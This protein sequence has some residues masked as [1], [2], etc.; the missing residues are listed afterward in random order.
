MQSQS[1]STNFGPFE[2]LTLFVVNTGL[3]GV[4]LLTLNH[5]DSLYSLLIGA[6]LTAIVMKFFK[7]K[8]TLKDER[9]DIF[10]LIILLIAAFFLAKPYLYVM[11][12][13]DEGLYVNMSTTY[14][15]TGST[16]IKDYF[17]E[18][19]PENYKIIYDENN[20]LNRVDIK[21]GEFEGSHLPG[22]YVRN[23]ANSEYV[24][25]FYPTHP[26]WMAIFA[27]IFGSDNRV[28]SLVFFALLSIVTFFL[29]AY[30]FSNRKKL[31]GYLVAL[32][33]AINP[34]FIFFGKFPVSE[35]VSVA[36]SSLGFYYLL[37][38]YK[39][40]QEDSE[41][42]KNPLYL[43]FSSLA[44]LNL[45]LNHI[46]GFLYI[47]FFY[48]LLLMTVV[49]INEKNLK[50][51][52]IIYY[53]SIFTAYLLS[54]WYGLHY[55]WPYSYDIYRLELQRF[56]IID[57]KLQLTI[58]VTLMTALPFVL[59]RFKSKIVELKNRFQPHAL[60][61]MVLLI[62]LMIPR[63]L[64]ILYQQG[65]A[66]NNLF[67]YLITS[68]SYITMLYLTPFGALLFL[69]GLNK[70]RKSKDAAGFALLAFLLLVWAMKVHFGVRIN[71]QFYASRYLF[72]EVVVYS[73]L[74]I[75]IYGGYLLEK[76]NYKKY[77]AALFIAGMSLY[78]VYYTA[79]QLQ[80]QEADGANQAL[81]QVAAHVNEKDLL[82]PTSL[83]HEILT[84]LRYYYSLPV[85]AF[86]RLSLDDAAFV[87]YLMDTYN[88]VFILAP[89]PLYNTNLE[90]IDIIAYKEGI[91]EHPAHK[92]PTEFFYHNTL[93]LYLYRINR[94]DYFTKNKIIRPK[95][96][97]LTNFYNDS[98]W[99]DGNGLIGGLNLK[100][101]PDNTYLILKTGGH[102]PLRG[103]LESLG[104]QIF[105]NDIE[106]KFSKKEG[107]DYY[108]E[109]NP[110]IK[111]LK[112]INEIRIK[113]STFKPK[114]FGIND[115]ERPLGIDVNYIMIK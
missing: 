98:Y 96:Y 75:G 65:I 48:L 36:F 86:N 70:L 44:F 61:I 1:S 11:G 15:A 78:S 17:R 59:S 32:F 51:N 77:L 47:P 108:F 102:N 79:Y 63:N 35:M 104:L 46:S 106:L 111:E 105:I 93:N 55:S 39:T 84:P 43:L 57:W 8:F 99:T 20:I 6:F 53:L 9:F 101:H 28:Y 92:I 73:L 112:E 67:Y 42:A 41:S 103:D 18:S 97:P 91:F 2:L 110:K 3:A 95:N 74:L 29:I 22:I 13:Q 52:L 94:Y 56:A 24:Y 80:G 115:D 58:M 10:L 85:F 71:Y 90:I 81:S 21:A 89:E 4:F 31:P 34:L 40:A 14:E 113:S 37:K 69:L 49:F 54:L 50:K 33:L 5:F 107:E 66:E 82:L 60:S 45:F 27:K 64:Y 87:E 83:G 100:M 12:G 72:N 109:V 25:Q 16:F 23:F 114:D 62:I 68:T 7:C 88:D 19:L 30:E 26:V 38:Y 76:T